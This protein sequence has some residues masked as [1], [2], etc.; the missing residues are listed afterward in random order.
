[1]KTTQAWLYLALAAP[2]CYFG[3]QLIAAPF[4][5]NYNFIRLAASNLG[6][7]ESLRPM[8]FNLG[9]MLGGFITMLG[10]YGY[11]QGF[12]NTHTPRVIVYL[13]CTAIVLVGL[14]SLWAGIYPM[15]DP[16]HAENPF[17]LFGL[18]PMPFLI[19]IAFWQHPKARV[20]LSL[21]ILLLL[22]LLPVMAGAIVIDRATYEGL[23]Q[24]LLALATYTPIA[25]GAILL[26]KQERR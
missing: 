8:V 12:Q 14:S 25:I 9:A 7:P 21:P 5:P 11:W 15:P 19:A 10:A 18:L 6:S 22:A 20:W 1:M 2:F 17:A 4:Y 26:V 3:I 23:L 16:K 13:V 24:R